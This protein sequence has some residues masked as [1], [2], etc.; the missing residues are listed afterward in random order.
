[1]AVSYN[2]AGP[3]IV[4]DGLV[5]YLD[6]GNP[7]SYNL[8]TPNVWRDISKRGNNGSLV[9][10]PVI[11]TDNQGFIR[12]DGVD[13]YIEVLDNS[14]LD[15]G[16]SN[17]TVEYWFRKLQTTLGFDNLWGVNKWN[18]GAQAG[19]NEWTLAIGNGSTGNGDIYGF[20]VQVGNT[21]YGSGT[22]P[23]TL[24]LNVWYQLIG[25][26]DG[27][28][29][30][31]YLNSVLKQD[32]SPAG[33]SSSSSINNV[34]RNLRINNSALNQYYTNCDNAI[35]RIYNRALSQAEITQNFNATRGRFGI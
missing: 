11:Q 12:C 32:V 23:D 8:S 27:G 20:A 3:R 35:V 13:D 28:T 18:T 14:S 21:S 10:G 25:I 6:A 5:L 31:T 26:R 17:F 30:K 34:S 33:F 7:N 9:N 29:L 22:S 15:F 1:M 19:T 16:T 24:S 2:F 4:K